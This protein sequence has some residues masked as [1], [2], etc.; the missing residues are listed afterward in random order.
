MP[1]KTVVHLVRH[2]EVANP[3]GVLYGRLPDFH[4]SEVGRQMAERVAEDLG[5]HDVVHLRSSPLE[6]AQ[7]TIAPLSTALSLPVIIDPRVIEAENY[8]Q[9]LKLSF[10]STLRRPQSWHY[11][12]NPLRPSWGES[13][14]SVVGRM[15]QAM[16]D[17]SAA[18]LG[19]EAVIMTHQMPIW[20]ARL[21][22]EGRRLLHDPRHRQCALASIT[23]FT[24]IEG[25]ITS[26]GYREPAA[27]LVGA[28]GRKF[29]AG[30]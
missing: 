19:H 10:S 9:G 1:E 26:V 7:E 24:Y 13:Y 3:T 12:L 15:R 20:M 29:V 14:R 8:L 21:D 2:G 16:R 17:A 25:H 23:S 11:F 28:L 18:A 4:L 27:D 5:Q 6:R 30:A 22:A